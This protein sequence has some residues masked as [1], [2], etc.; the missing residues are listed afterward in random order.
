VGNAGVIFDFD[1]VIADSEP[2]QYAAYSQVLRDFGVSVTR[3]EYG[4]EWIAAGRGPE[5]AVEQYEL[6]LTADEVK[7]RK[8]PI[9]HELLRAK[10]TLMP[11][12]REALQRL[13]PH[14][15]IA[16][17]TNSSEVDACFVLDRF[18]VRRYF[19]ALVTRECY[20]EPKPAP[21]AFV[22]AAAALSCE[23]RR[24]VV[25]ED[26]Y[27]GI[28]SAVRAGCASIAVPHSFTENHDF[29]LA[30][31]IVSSLDKVTVELIET[32]LS[33]RPLEGNG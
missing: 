9:Y 27:K 22:A 26:A 23:P 29:S 10:V 11:G 32:L 13:S 1:G 2:L 21:D 18:D 28:V 20:E 16:L 3:E 33:H 4:R 24:C 31:S 25:I 5:Y 30:D 19:T 6:P 8:N 14:F 15:P 7:R 17:A 12:A